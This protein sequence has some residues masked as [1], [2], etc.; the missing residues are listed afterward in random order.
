MLFDL[1]DYRTSGLIGN[2]RYISEKKLPNKIAGVR[3]LTS[4][5]WYTANA[6]RHAHK[7]AILVYFD[8]AMKFLPLSQKENA[9]N[10]FIAYLESF[11]ELSIASRP[12]WNMIHSLPLVMVPGGKVFQAGDYFSVQDGEVNNADEQARFIFN[13]RGY[14]YFQETHPQ[15]AYNNGS[16]LYMNGEYSDYHA[17]H[18]SPEELEYDKSTH[19]SNRVGTPYTPYDSAIADNYYEKCVSNSAAEK[20]LMIALEGYDSNFTPSE[21]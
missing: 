15:A 2:G 7:N 14:K 9:V 16:V 13:W 20:A 12:Y 19:W 6:T 1:E 8:A 10:K 5:L 3:G 18:L 17:K 21:I 11:R 4:D